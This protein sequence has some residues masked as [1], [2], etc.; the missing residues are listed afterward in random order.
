MPTLHGLV[1]LNAR[2]IPHHDAII[3]GDVVI[4]WSQLHDEM[5]RFAAAL[6]ALGVSYNDRVAIVSSN[7][8]EY[9][10]AGF[11]AWQLGAVM[12]AVN[13]RL[14]QPELAHIFADCDP[15][16]IVAEPRLVGRVVAA[17][18]GIPVVALGP[19]D[20]HPDLS[21]MAATQ[22][23]YPGNPVD[24]RDD[25][26]II[27]TSGT[28]G[29][30]KGALH[31]HHSAI[32]SAWANVLAAELRPGERYL[33]IA[34]LFHAGGLVF[35]SAITLLGG[36][37]ILV[38]GF[39]AERVIETIGH[40]KAGAMMTVP[41][42]LQML[43]AALPTEGP[44]DK[45]ASWN[46]AIVGGAAVT[47]HTLDELFE[48]LPQVRISQVCGQTESGPAGLYSSHDQM[49]ERPSATSHQA[50]PF[51][52]ARVVDRNGRDVGPGDVG[53][54][55]FRGETIMK[56]YWRRPEETAET[57]RDGWL[58]TGDLVQL[59]ADGSVTL[60]DRVKDMIISGGRNVYSVE[61]EQAVNSH[62]AVLDSAVVGRPDPLWGESVVVVATPKPGRNI[63]LEELR[64][65]CS[66]LIADY[67]LPRALILSAIPR[68]ANGK[69][70]K[71]LLRKMFADQTVKG[72]S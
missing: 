53:E 46:R 24:E 41:A 19:S 43:L 4:S 8:A 65:Y 17:A 37:H 26:M 51:V 3:D 61:V 57:I 25:A 59:D 66:A 2:R 12:V 14:A 20:R 68:N 70:Q 33:H 22:P 47:Q 30:P 5:Q 11:G 44:H 55:I 48:R 50:E 45:L 71:A 6:A 23:A 13:T 54:V 9:L 21:A 31:T 1:G 62:P 32:W 10:K 58:H 38:P 36:C 39:D 18:D 34:P 7:T 60:V 35:W 49:R 64:E 69:V 42:V 67:K 72:S 63:T 52:D 28:S 40:T 16:V 27:Y 56:Q 29:T 15:A